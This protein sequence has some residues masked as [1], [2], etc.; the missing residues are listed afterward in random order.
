VLKAQIS[1]FDL[2]VKDRQFGREAMDTI[3]RLFSNPIVTG[4]VGLIVG[5]FIGLVILGWWLFPVQWSNAA[6]ADLRADAQ[7]TYLRSCIDAYGYNGDAARAKACYDSL[8][9]GANAA[10]QEIVSNPTTQNPQMIAAFA[11]L[12][13]GQGEASAASGQSP[14]GS[15][16]P[17]VVNQAEQVYPG[18]VS[19]AATVYPGAEA[20]DLPKG[21]TEQPTAK[22]GFPSWLTL[23]CVVGLIGIAI[24]ALLFLLN[25]LHILNLGWFNKSEPAAK[26]GEAPGDYDLEGQQISQNISSY[27]LGDDLFDDVY[28]IE[29]DGDFLGEYGVAIADSSGV[30]GPKRV[31]AFELWLFDKNHIPTTTLVLMSE[32]AYND[33]VKRQKLETKGAPV[34]ISLN[35]PVLLETNNLRLVAKATQLEYGQGP[36]GSYFERFVLD[37]RIYRLD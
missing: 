26:D 22:G 25:K 28:S 9:E 1:Q 32:Q 34:M 5:L 33:P 10:L 3:K 7:V 2:Q 24:V 23:L 16:Y 20:F 11:N 35:Q 19:S 27:K 15:T 31:S 30:G 12:A 37:L 8:G 13:L 6:P 36:S 18:A 4:V 17:E 14:S 21:S 29:S